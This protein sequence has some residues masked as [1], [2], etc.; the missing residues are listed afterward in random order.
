MTTKKPSGAA[1]R[2]MRKK[3]AAER[4]EGAGEADD[5]AGVFAALG[6]PPLD[7]PETAMSWVRRYQLTALHVAATKPMT[8]ALRERIKNIKEICATVG[9][10]QSRSDLEEIASRCETLLE[11]A[12]PRGAV[13]MQPT[14]GLTRPPTARGGKRGPKPLPP[15]EK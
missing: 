15:E 10:T 5:G 3:R 6:P 11:G 7:D 4:S 9:M 13:N 14:T 2:K 1:Y 8:D 12:R